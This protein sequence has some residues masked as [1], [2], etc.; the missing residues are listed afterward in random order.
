M[1]GKWVQDIEGRPDDIIKVESEDLPF[2]SPKVA[3][4]PYPRI[5]V[6]SAFS[7]DQ[8]T[9][10]PQIPHV[11][12]V[13]QVS[14]TASYQAAENFMEISGNP[15][16]FRST[17]FSSSLILF[18]DHDEV[19]RDTD[20]IALV[21]QEPD[22]EGAW[23]ARSAPDEPPPSSR[24]SGASSPGPPYSGRSRREYSAD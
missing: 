15:K 12:G 6:I 17:S 4:K 5:S 22:A 7:S 13:V 8:G 1:D 19:L 24:G 10:V 2:V 3:R 11:I 23:E 9:Q 20:H 18:I 21:L 14:W 16:G